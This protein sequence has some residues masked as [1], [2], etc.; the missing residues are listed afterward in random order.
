VDVPAP[1]TVSEGDET[2]KKKLFSMVLAA[3]VLGGLIAIASQTPAQ[4][5]NNQP[6]ASPPTGKVAI[7]NLSYVVKNYNKYLDFSAKMK[8]DVE[9]FE[10]QAKGKKA[11]YDAIVKDASDPKNAAQ[12][13][14]YEKDLKAVQ[15]EHEDITAA[16]KQYVSQ[17]SDEQMVVLYREIQETAVRYANA[18][19]YEMVLH[20][21]DAPAN[22]PDYYSPSNIARKMQAGALMPM[23]VNP[24]L[25]ISPLVVQTLNAGY[26]TTQPAATP[27][28]GK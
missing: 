27:P 26:K 2:V 9:Q 8:K 15:R 16:M 1:G 19:S 7:L 11:A 4:A 18:R 25:D 13:E 17:K 14:K 3:M 24:A 21:N 6:A 20:F 10:V 12:R 22:T 5:P 28:A 23:Y